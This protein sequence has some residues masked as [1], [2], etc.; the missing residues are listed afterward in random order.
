MMAPTPLLDWQDVGHGHGPMRIVSVK[1]KNQD[2]IVMWNQEVTMTIPQLDRD[3]ADQI[4]AEK[5][6]ADATEHPPGMMKGVVPIEMTLILFPSTT[7]PWMPTR[8]P[9]PVYCEVNHI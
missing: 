1:G 2:G 4:S 9:K 6:V 8:G 5:T 3:V 7:L